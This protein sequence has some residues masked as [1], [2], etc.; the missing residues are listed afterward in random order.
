M[1]VTPDSPSDLT[2]RTVLQRA[3]AAGLLATPAAGFLAACG[4][5]AGTDGDAVGEK[6]ADNPFGVVKDRGLEVAGFNG[7]FGE[8]YFNFNIEKF[9]GKYG[10]A[11]VKFSKTILTDFQPRFYGGNPPDVLNNSSPETIPVGNL[12]KGE[13]LTDLAELLDADSYDEPGKKVRDTLVAGTVEEGTYDGKVYTLNYAYSIYGHWYNQ[14]L[15]EKKGWTLPKTW[16]EFTTLAEAAKKDG[17]AAYTFPGIHPWYIHNAFMEWVFKVGGDDAVKAIDNLEPNAWKS[18]AVKTT[19]ERM[20]EMVG[21]GWVQAGADGLDHTTTQQSV[22]DEKS[23]F[24]WCGS[25]LEGEMAKTLGTA[26]LAVTAPWALTGSDKAPYG[27]VHAAP[28]EGFVIPKRARNVAG[29]LEFLRQMLSKESARKFAELTKSLPVVK[30]AADG[31]TVSN[32]LA[33][34]SKVAAAAPAGGV[35]NWRFNGWY[36][37]SAVQK[38]IFTNATELMAGRMTAAAFMDAMQSAADEVA[39]DDK[40][41]KQKR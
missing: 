3:A 18:D 19:A 17:I 26:K 1:T 40:I 4:D 36:E 6:T 33:S 9:K 21:K 5:D 37:G 39:K 2:R 23:L 41:L 20:A 35:I 12:V 14:A 15:F 38:G 29:G 27:V 7:G 30:G 22:I 13:Q 11:E 28:G 31:L 34:A 25:W 8:D 10:A 16:E 32:A 24:I